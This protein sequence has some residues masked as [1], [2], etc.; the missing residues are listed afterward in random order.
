MG[1]ESPLQRSRK[2]DTREDQR[3]SEV[4]GFDFVE[5]EN[6]GPFRPVECTRHLT[7]G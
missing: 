2:G 7:L 4:E 6:V 5:T 1:T 3:K